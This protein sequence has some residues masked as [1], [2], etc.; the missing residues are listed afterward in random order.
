MASSREFEAFYRE[1][2][3]KALPTDL[4]LEELRARFDT[5]LKQYPPAPEVRFESFSM[6]ELSALWAFAPDVNRKRILLFFFGGGF[7]VGS[8]DSHKNLIGR[9]SATA[10]AAVCAIQYR[11]APEHPFPAALDDAL[12]AYRW[13]LHHPYARSRIVFCGLSAGGGL[14]LSLLL[15]LKMEKIATP[16]GAI[17]LCPWV[18]LKMR[19]ESIRKNAGKDLLRTERLAWCAEK[20][21]A[22]SDL[23]SPLLSPLNGSLEGLPPLFIQSGTL[24]LLHTE[25]LQLAEKAQKQ[26]VAVTLDV[27]PNLV[28]GW[29]LFAPQFPEAQEGLERAGQFVD[30]LFKSKDGE[31]GH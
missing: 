1:A 15:R 22:G 27:W 10:N 5:W 31:A 14:A 26:G 6:G 25:A 24:D 20:Y 28:H 21:A 9:L 12:T 2:L 23:A 17:C 4:P 7:T 29:Q 19:G 3:S 30:S 13:L 18:D 8:V 16:A 11:L